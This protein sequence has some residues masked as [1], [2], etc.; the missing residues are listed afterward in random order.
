M[1]RLNVEGPHMK[2]HLE[3]ALFFTS[4]VLPIFLS[5]CSTLQTH[6][7]PDSFLAYTVHRDD[8]LLDRYAP[9]FVIEK[10][11]DRYN[12]IGTPSA[13]IAAD[14]N[15]I[16]FVDSGKAAIYAYEM[17]F[18]TEKGAYK[19]LIYRIHFEKVPFG[20]APFYL[21]KGKNVGLLVIITLNHR[22]EPI[23]YTTV[24]TCGCYLA[25]SPTS[26]MEGDAFPD[27]W[28][29][30]RQV[31]HGE[32]LPGFLDFREFFPDT[33]KT[34]IVIKQGSHR[35]KDIRLSKADTSLHYQMAEAILCPLSELEQ[36]PLQNGKTTSFYETSGPRKGY[37]KGSHKPWER[38]LM[39]WWAL[40]WRIGE[41]KK[42]GKDKT[43]GTLFYTSL[44]PW[45]R[46]KSDMRDFAA[47]LRYWKWGL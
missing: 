33:E 22:N 13:E 6:L 29:K 30:G 47:F 35:V 43:D 40:D 16:V 1:Q 14:G 20:L 5:S 42:F 32:T 15:E 26:F 31:V 3:R 17:D 2:T 28:G 24:H 45:A 23:L 18:S 19:N 8:T 34:I 36:L 44:K 11:Q 46:K 10:P 9:V 41:D 7:G 25:F 21:G 27:G 4:L 39:S 37:V 12:R 38:L